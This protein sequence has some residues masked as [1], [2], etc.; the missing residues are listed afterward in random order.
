LRHF[1]VELEELNQALLEMG[2]RVESSIHCSVQAL[3]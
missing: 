3:V 2:A 1:A